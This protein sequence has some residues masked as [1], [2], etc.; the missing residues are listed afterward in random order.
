MGPPRNVA[1]R[2]DSG[3]PKQPPWD[4][5]GAAAPGGLYAGVYHFD[6]PSAM[7]R[8]VATLTAAAQH[9]ACNDGEFAGWLAAS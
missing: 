4:G 1:Y 8:A 2:N 5:V 3:H 7:G 9:G 6:Q